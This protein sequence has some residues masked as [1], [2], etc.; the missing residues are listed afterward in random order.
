MNLNWLDILFIAAGS[1]QLFLWIFLFTLP[2]RKRKKI[3]QS[4]FS[5]SV[6][7]VICAQNEYHNLLKLLPSLIKQAYNSFEIIVVNDRSTDKTVHLAELFDTV[8]FIHLAKT[9]EGFNSKKFALK[10]GIAASNYDYILVTDADCLPQSDRWI[11]SMMGQVGSTTEIVLGLSPYFS[12]F[13]NNLLNQIIQ[14]ETTF[15]ALQ[16]SSL[17]L[18]GFPYMGLG[19]NMLYKKNIFT[20]SSITTKNKHLTGGDD[21]LLINEMGTKLNTVINLAPNS[22]VFSHPKNTFKSW[23]KQKRRHLSV[24]SS[25]SL[26]SK[27]LLSI[28]NLSHALFIFSLIISLYTSDFTQFIIVAYLLRT[29]LLFVIFGRVCKDFKG[30]IKPLTIVLGDFFYPFYLFTLGILSIVFKTNTWK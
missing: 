25:Y 13:K 19:R 16:M 21:D 30:E 12:S 5:P 7:I 6:S 2:I 18:A 26:Y 15:T 8:K 14:F 4:E 10:T 22:F 17:T 23:V 3:T 29:S 9:P 20:E 24:S 11:S 1:V 28:I 27:F